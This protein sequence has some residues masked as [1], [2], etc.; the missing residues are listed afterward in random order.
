MRLLD[1]ICNDPIFRAAAV[2]A[3]IAPLVALDLI[4]GVFGGWAILLAFVGAAAGWLAWSLFRVRE[5]N[6]KRRL[7]D[8]L[9][10]FE[11]RRSRELRHRLAEDETFHTHCHEC[12]H[13]SQAQRHCKLNLRNRR[14]WIKLD[15]SA[16]ALRYCLYW[17]VTA[18][19][20]LLRDEDLQQRRL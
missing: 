2:V 4:T 3:V 1:E 18:P 16:S 8:D 7:E 19:A 17:N 6:R 12:G 10:H 14:M 15:L 9:P 11:E 5:E 13:F 20:H